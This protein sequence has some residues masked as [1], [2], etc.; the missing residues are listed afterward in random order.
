MLVVVVVEHIVEQVVQQVQEVADL[1]HQ[2][3]AATAEMLLLIPAVVV[4]AL[5][6][7]TS[8]AQLVEPA[9]RVLLLSLYLQQITQVQLPAH[10]L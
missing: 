7:Q 8:Q 5:V 9:D 10:R 1:G 3:M 4:V 2:Q 6:A